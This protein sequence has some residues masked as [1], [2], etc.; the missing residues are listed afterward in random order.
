[1]EEYVKDP[2]ARENSFKKKE[3]IQHALPAFSTYMDS[4]PHPIWEGSQDV[5]DCYWKT[6]E[7]AFRN[8]RISKRKWFCFQLCHHRI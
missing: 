2:F 1:M 5:I 8:L 3:Y 4:L 7:I 6:W